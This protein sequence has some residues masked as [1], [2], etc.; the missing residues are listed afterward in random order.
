MLPGRPAWRRI[1]AR[2]GRSILDPDQT[3]NR[4][5]LGR[6]V[7]SSPAERLFLNRVLHPLVLEKKKQEVR[8][9]ERLGRHKIF[10]SEAAL[11]IEAGLVPFFDKV[12]LAYCPESMQVK[13]LMKRDGIGREEAWRK[14]RSQMR[15]AEKI[16]HADYLIDTSG[17]VRETEAQVEKLRRSL[18]A[19]FRRKQAERE[20]W[21]VSVRRRARRPEAGS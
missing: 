16:A 1:V 7:F 19:D 2:F 10:V 11:T 3:I 14:I 12:V 13:R 5:R 17:T 18:L 6:I 8:E 9:L 20:K 21:R 4:K 15:P